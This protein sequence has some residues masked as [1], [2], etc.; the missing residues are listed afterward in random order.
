MGFHLSPASRA[1]VAAVVA[2]CFCGEFTARKTVLKK[3]RMVRLLHSAAE[4]LQRKEPAKRAKEESPWRQPWV[5][6]R[7]RSKPAK[8]AKENQPGLSFARFAGLPACTD[9]PWLTPW[10]VFL[11]P[12][13][14]LW[15]RQ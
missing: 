8:R 12:L 13:R 14:G 1:L 10:A 2:L 7:I 3:Q 9:Y 15:L 6:D 5:Y 11:R 4:W